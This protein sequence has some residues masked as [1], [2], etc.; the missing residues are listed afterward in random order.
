MAIPESPDRSLILASQSP[1]RSALLRQAGIEFQTDPPRIEEPALRQGSFTPAAFAQALSYFKAR[2]V[3]YD[4]PDHIV[5]GADTVVAVG[6]RMFGK[7]ADV[8]DARQILLTL[9]GTTQDVITGVTLYHAGS[10]RRLIRHDLTRVTMRTM[11]DE[12]LNDYLDSGE[13]EG[14]AGAYGI[15]DTADRFVTRLEGSFSNVVGLPVE[16]VSKML[17]EFDPSQPAVASSSHRP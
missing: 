9:T 11:T 15:Q 7:P 2:S 5:L 16:L 13:W 8:D 14:K 4:Y 17:E 12:E 1:R 3:A 10:D 6:P